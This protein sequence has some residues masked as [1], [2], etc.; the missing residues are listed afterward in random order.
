MCRRKGNIPNCTALL[1]TATSTE[2][3]ALKGIHCLLFLCNFTATLTG[4]GTRSLKMWL[5]SRFKYFKLQCF[6]NWYKQEVL[7]DLLNE[8]IR[9]SWG[10]TF[11]HPEKTSI[12]S[13]DEAP[14]EESEQAGLDK[15][16]QF[17][18]GRL[19]F[20]VL[21]FTQQLVTTL[22]WASLLVLFFQQHLLTSCL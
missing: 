21:Y 8:A 4:F 16:P 2:D 17:P 14:Q 13:K 15:L 10:T 12:I 9:P 1:P 22:H 6:K 11:L 20:I 3:E 5:S 19:C 18:I 7:S